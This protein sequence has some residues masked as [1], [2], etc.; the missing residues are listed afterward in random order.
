MRSTTLRT[1]GVLGVGVATVCGGALVACGGDDSGVVVATD[2]GADGSPGI[3]SGLDAGP[4][5]AHLDGSTTDGE[6]TDGATSDGD[7]ALA[8]CDSPATGIYYVD[9][10]AG[11]DTT[12]GSG[13]AGGAVAGRCAF[14]TIT[15]ALTTLGTPT[16]ATTIHVLGISTVSEGETF[17]LVVPANVT[18]DSA[19]GAVTVALPAS[20]MTNAFTLASPT[21]GLKGLT[22]DG[23]AAAGSTSGVVVNTGAAASTFVNAVEVKGFGGPGIQVQGSAAFTIDV[24]TSLHDNGT[25]TG[26]LK[27]SGLYVTGTASVT[28]NI[29]AGG[30]A[31]SFASNAGEGVLVDMT[32]TLAFTGVPDANASTSGTGTIVMHDNA[33]NG[34]TIASTA[35]IGGGATTLTGVV[36]WHNTLEGA[37][38]TAGASV[39][40]RSS[41]VLDNADNG[42]LVS[43]GPAVVLTNPVSAIDLGS[44]HDGMNI[45][46]AATNGNG[47]A[48]I[49]NG[50]TGS[51]AAPAAL[52]AQGNTF[53]GHDC[54][55]SASSAVIL[56]R[57]NCATGSGNDVGVKGTN[58]TVSTTYC[59]N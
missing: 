12:N 11:S 49:C 42:I 39:T 53:S 28:A 3:D 16:A 34:I 27:K 59:T 21:S 20:S 38:I 18:I 43:G 57:N 2:A 24:G 29:A 33:T 35:G 40:V 15:F 25:A 26:T 36:L 45:V 50:V 14:K 46:Q 13:T 9:P 6:T 1:W 55:L 41:V 44:A 56:S 52:N 4:D 10:V 58:A 31:V 32:A 19:G 47:A 5:A 48:G 51:A 54:S 23:S 7:A 22:I 17:P 8:A 37:A 30:A